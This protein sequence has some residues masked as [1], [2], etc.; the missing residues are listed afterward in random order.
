M[1]LLFDQGLYS[2]I[3]TDSSVGVGWKLYT[4]TNG[5]TN[6]KATYPTAADAAALTN[7]NS[8]PVVTGA[9]GRFAI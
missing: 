7:A 9:D 2:V 5:T 6:T 1:A 8:N 4:Y 3:D